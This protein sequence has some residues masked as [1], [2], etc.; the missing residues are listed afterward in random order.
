MS[1]QFS[2]T[3]VAII[4]PFHTDGSIDF[5]SLTKLVDFQ[6]N[7]GINYLVVMGTTGE[8]ATLNK[9]EK[10]AVIDHII[11]INN[12]RVPLVIGIGGNN[13]NEVVA[14]IKSFH[15]Y[16]EIAGIL[17]VAP[18]YNKPSQEGLYQHYKMIAEASPVPVI[19]YNVPGRSAV[20]ISAETTLRLANDFEN[21][22]AVK[23]ASG[24][25][26][27][28]MEIIKNKPTDFAVISGDDA[29]TFP[30][31]CLGAE[32]V[33][34][35][36]ANA[37]P[38]DF[39]DMVNAALISEIAKAKALHFKLFEIIQNLFTEGNPAGIKAILHINK[40]I[41]NNFRLPMTGVSINHYSKL[42][43]L[44]NQTR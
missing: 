7:N 28:I 22:V 36:V 6:L 30:L 42:E 39:S 12:K 37:Y 32:G 23:E 20:N 15:A 5:N 17:S 3:G 11:K 8:A 41:E 43:E 44:V 33:I 18:Y 40:L 27:Q 14:G 19:L 9:D 26:E 13:T 4:T 38:K 31:I 25:M 1:H 34:S 35:V 10:K 29:L 24:N 2:G 16:N 21:V